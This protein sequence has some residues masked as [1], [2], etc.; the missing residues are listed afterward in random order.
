MKAW[1]DIEKLT[2]SVGGRLTATVTRTMTMCGAV[3]ELR[4]TALSR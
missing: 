1:H 2:R 4:L 3:D